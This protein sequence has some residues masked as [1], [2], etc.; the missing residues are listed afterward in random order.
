[1]G[2]EEQERLW[3]DT[4]FSEVARIFF[5]N[6]YLIDSL[7]GLLPSKISLEHAHFVLDIGCG[8]G[9]W[10]R[11]LARQYPDIRVIGIDTSR[12]LITEA[13]CKAQEEELDTVSYLQF[14]ASQPLDFPANKC[15]VIHV[16]S[17]VSFLIT[18][19]RDK[20]IE[21]MIRILKPGGWLNIVDYE[22]GSTSSEAFNRLSVMGLKGLGAL[23]GSFAPTSTSYGVAARLYGFLV[24]AGMIDVSYTLHT[25]DYGVNSHTGTARF[26]DDL[27][28]GMM[29]F[30][31]FVLYLGLSTSEAFDELVEK[32]REEFHQPDSCGYA[33]LISAIGRKDPNY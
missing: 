3:Q 32:A 11:R 16:Q 7:G 17:L 26:L 2:L 1:M 5:G 18:P 6:P 24:E 12:A 4:T 22:Q 33:Y 31:P 23:G 8:S 13:V 10:S 25:V 20:I 14:D 27:V 29:N 30:K 9:E 28:V 19:M 15:D 21:D